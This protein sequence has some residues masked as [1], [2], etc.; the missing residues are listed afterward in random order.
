[1]FIQSV[2]FIYLISLDLDGKLYETHHFLTALSVTPN[3]FPICKNDVSLIKFLSS[4]LDGLFT[5]LDLILAQSTHKLLSE[6]TS[7]PQF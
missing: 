5:F 4:S 3:I 1:M 6:Q 2:L 7:L